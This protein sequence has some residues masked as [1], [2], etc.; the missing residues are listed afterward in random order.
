MTE[1]L[2]Q[3]VAKLNELAKAEASA[4]YKQAGDEYGYECA[5]LNAAPMLL[6]VL[7]E[8]RAGDTERLEYAVRYLES[9]NCP[10]Q[11][12]DAVSRYRDMVRK[13]EANE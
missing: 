6:D 8:I 13:M 12:I 3:T 2:I 9:T 10:T 4:T 11:C 1:S 5:V 7:G